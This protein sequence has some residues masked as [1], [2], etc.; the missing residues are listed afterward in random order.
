MIVVDGPIAS[1]KTK[2]AQDLAKELDMRYIEHANMDHFLINEYGFDFRSLNPK[3]PKSAWFMDEAQFLAD[4]SG[5]L[6]GIL[7]MHLYHLR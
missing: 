2:F 4:P 5:R 1:G 6:T 7:Q 3:L